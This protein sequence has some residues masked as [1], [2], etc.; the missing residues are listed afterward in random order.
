HKQQM[1]HKLEDILAGLC[2]AL[3]RNFL[4]NLGKGKELLEPI[5]FQGGVAA[6]VGM[7]EA[8]IRS[9]EEE[10]IV[11]QHYDVMGAIGAAILAREKVERSNT[12][13]FKGFETAT[14]NFLQSSFE[15]SGCANSCE[16]IQIHEEEHL[17][18]RWGDRCGKWSARQTA[19]SGA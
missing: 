16:I 18:A 15:C 2:E 11:P 17:L 12:T 1:G 3:V 14:A 19:Q 8:F 13:S 9:L 4:S 6:N 7:K 10:V 5:V